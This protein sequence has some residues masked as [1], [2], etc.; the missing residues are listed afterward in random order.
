MTTSEI[1]IVQWNGST[2][3]NFKVLRSQDKFILNQESMK[4]HDH[5][6]IKLQSKNYVYKLYDYS[7]IFKQITEINVERLKI[8]IT[9]VKS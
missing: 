2:K 6:T 5:N 8:L 9:C 3:C 1:W 4:T 7:E